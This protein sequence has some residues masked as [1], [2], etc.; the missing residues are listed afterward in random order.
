MEDTLI[1]VDD[2]FFGLV[3][4]HFQKEKGQSKK[5]LQTFRN[6]CKI[7]SRWVNLTEKEFEDSQINKFKENDNHIRN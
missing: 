5:Y 7:A 1:F 4:K 6:I 3:K 2:G